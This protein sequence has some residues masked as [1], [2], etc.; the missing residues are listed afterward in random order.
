[1]KCALSKKESCLYCMEENCTILKKLMD[2]AK[3]LFESKKTLG[4]LKL[5]NIGGPR[6]MTKQE[7]ADI[8]KRFFGEDE[9]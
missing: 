5:I 2:V 7:K 9:E 3:E 8:L 6:E 4:M 1:M